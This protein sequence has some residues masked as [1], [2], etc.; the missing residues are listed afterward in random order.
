MDLDICYEY[1]IYLEYSQYSLYIQAYILHMG[2]QY[3]RVGKNKN[4]LHYIPYTEHLVRRVT[5][6]KARTFQDKHLVDNNW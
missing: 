3:T 1:M 6:H 4:R 5:V 2:C